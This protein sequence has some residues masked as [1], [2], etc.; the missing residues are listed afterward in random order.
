MTQL[1]LSS[2]V[3]RRQ[4]NSQETATFFKELQLFVGMTSLMNVKD[5]K[6]SLNFVEFDEKLFTLFIRKS[7][8]WHFTVWSSIVNRATAVLKLVSQIVKFQRIAG[9]D[10]FVDECQR[11]Q[12][13]SSKLGRVWRKIW[14]KKKIL[15]Q[16]LSKTCQNLSKI[17]SQKLVEFDE[18]FV[19]VFIKKYF[20]ILLFGHQLQYTA[21][22]CQSC[23]FVLKIMSFRLLVQ[24]FSSGSST[25]KCYW[26]YN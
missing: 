7:Y 24:N 25:P 13:L 11:C 5:V 23:N 17:L 8:L 22:T 14:V 15:S 18:K 19:T 6:D 20:Y 3:T 10:D 21:V 9:G 12:S 16:N 26:T 2:I 1:P 4:N